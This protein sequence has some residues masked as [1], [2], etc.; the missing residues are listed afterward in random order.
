MIHREVCEQMEQ[1]GRPLLQY[2]LTPEQ[3][4]QLEDELNQNR[5]I[6]DAPVGYSRVEIYF[7]GQSEPCH[8][9]RGT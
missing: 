4:D 6:V 3:W 8:I 1:E 9:K 7:N 2:V 5:N